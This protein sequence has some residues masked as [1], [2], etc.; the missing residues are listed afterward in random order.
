MLD[1]TRDVV[2]CLCITENNRTTT[3][4]RESLLLLYM[5]IQTVPPARVRFLKLRRAY[6]AIPTVARCQGLFM[7]GHFAKDEYHPNG[8]Q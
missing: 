8:V 2:L 1:D 7:Y 4:S 5:H 3:S 6:A